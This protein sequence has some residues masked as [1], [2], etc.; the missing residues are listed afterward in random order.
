MPP[1]SKPSD[2]CRPATLCTSAADSRCFRSCASAAAAR[3][4]AAEASSSAT[5]ALRASASDTPASVSAGFSAS[6]LPASLL[7]PPPVW[8]SALLP[9]AARAASSSATLA[10]SAAT[11][12]SGTKGLLSGVMT[13]VASAPAV[14]VAR[15]ASS[16]CTRAATAS[17]SAAASAAFMTC[18]QN[19]ERL[20]S[21]TCLM[22]PLLRLLTSNPWDKR[23][24]CSQH[25]LCCQ[26]ALD[27]LSC[28]SWARKHLDRPM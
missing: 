13:S 10:S 18:R 6:V 11:C 27:Q 28:Q 2:C 22:S 25:R 5:R 4:S 12:W 7:S 21:S 15:R 14:C 9:A 1:A 8:A 19:L 16:S 23:Q 20:S 17:A 3:S 24:G 26:M